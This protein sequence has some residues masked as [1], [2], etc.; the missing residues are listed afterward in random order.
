MQLKVD[1]SIHAVVLSGDLTDNGSQEGWDALLKGGA[2]ENFRAKLVLA[3]GNHDINLV[4]ESVW[5]SLFR[6]EGPRRTGA[7]ARALRYLRAASAV[8][9]ERAWVLCP[10]SGAFATLQSTMA[11][12]AE[13][14]A[15]W[16]E[17]LDKPRKASLLPLQ[18]F[19][20]LF[21]MAVAVSNS[22]GNPQRVRFIVWNSVKQNEW[23]AFNAIE[24]VEKD[25][26]ERA[27]RLVAWL[28]ADTPLVHVMHHQIGL[29]PPGSGRRVKGMS[30]WRRLT[31][32]GMAMQNPGEVLD[33]LGAR[34]QRTVVLHGHHHKLFMLDSP[35]AKATIVSAPSMTLGCEES[36]FNG[37]EPGPKGRWLKLTLE[38]IGAETLVRRVD[39]EEWSSGRLGAK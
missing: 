10:Y 37:S 26:F 36:F 27:E 3:P 15:S 18:L 23:P 24:E 19:E 29:P 6:L 21:P 8:M 32:A 5:K 33:W 12:A 16:N 17:G 2:I 1:E 28:G 25:Q 34:T 7:N 22:D 20:R 31:T 14:L 13:D 30:A 39:V 38:V 35:D 11:R 9:G 4:Y